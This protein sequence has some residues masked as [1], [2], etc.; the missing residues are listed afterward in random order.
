MVATG[1]LVP[2]D[3]MIASDSATLDESALTGESLP[4]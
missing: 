3:G 2:V 1:E 4:I